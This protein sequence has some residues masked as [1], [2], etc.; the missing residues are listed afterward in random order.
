MR[1]FLKRVITPPLL[2]A[3]AA[4]LLVEEALWRLARVYA[5]LAKL[6]LMRQIETGVQKLP[7]AGALAVFAVPSLLLA[8]VKLLAMYWLAGGRPALGITTIL[9]AKIAGT[10]LVARIYQLT[11]PALITWRWFALAESQILALRAA[12]YGLWANSAPGR[13]AIAKLRALRV[14]L[15][16]T[17][18]LLRAARRHWLQTRWAASRSK[19]GSPPGV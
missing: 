7:P 18:E 9:A 11:R 4:F 13:L 17:R 8:P 1:R 16:A 6:P 12:A 5:L 19:L 15:R 3:A 10:A 14:K 2:A